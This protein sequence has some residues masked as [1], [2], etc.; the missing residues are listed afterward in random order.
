MA[1]PVIYEQR[2]SVAYVTIN[3]P[4]RRNALGHEVKLG[5]VNAFN[6]VR[7]DPSVRVAVLTGAGDKA[8][9]VQH[10]KVIRY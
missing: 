4:E 1:D 3:R 2:G 7:R 8:F 9:P 6:K 10:C 5:L